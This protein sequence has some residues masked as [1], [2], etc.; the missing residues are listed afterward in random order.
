[1]ELDTAARVLKELGHA[2]RLGIYRTLI[3]AGHQGMPVGE[4]Q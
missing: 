4:L 2:T 1:M 3:K